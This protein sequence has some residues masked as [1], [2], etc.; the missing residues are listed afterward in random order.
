MQIINP[1][2]E[3]IISEIKEDTRQTLDS[4][5]ESLK[6]AQ[7]LW[8]NT[9]LKKRIEILKRFS[10]LLEKHIEELAAILTS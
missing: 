1:A 6:K 7:T 9:P 3:E 10:E 8:Q 5:F 2:T 4:K